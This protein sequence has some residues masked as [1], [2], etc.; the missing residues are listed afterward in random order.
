MTEPIAEL[1]G[2]VKSYRMDDVEVPV[3]KGVDLLVQRGR[4]TIVYGPSGSGK[5][6]LLNLIGC[7]DRCDAG[8][9]F[10]AGRDV[11]KLSD[12]ELADF[13]CEHIGFVFQ[14]FSL[15]PVLTAFENVEY[16]L[17]LAGLDRDVRRRRVQRMLERVGL[18]D[19]LAKRPGQ[20]SGGQRQRVAIA[21]ALIRRPQLVI[22]DE[23][24]ANLDSHSGAAF[25]D[26]LRHMQAQYKTSFLFSTHDPRLSK[27]ADDVLVVK[28]GKVYVK[29]RR[30][31]STRAA[32]DSLDTSQTADAL[33]TDIVE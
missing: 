14:S 2:V 21:R 15:I 33:A 32:T 26:L 4:F 22:A 19:Q 23:P 30:P 3:L 8:D 9:L 29:K 20:L 1:R 28:D 24:T 5:T 11:S 12:D 16:P 17:M 6:T 18:A 31:V 27:V 13:R 25:I 7:L 10:V